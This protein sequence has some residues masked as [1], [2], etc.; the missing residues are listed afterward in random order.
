MAKMCPYRKITSV[1]SID[2]GLLKCTICTKKW[3]KTGGDCPKGVNP[4]TCEIIPKRKSKVRRVKAWAVITTVAP[5]D[6]TSEFKRVAR[7]SP[8]KD[9][10]YVTVPCTILIDE[11]WLTQS[12]NKK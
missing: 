12:E 10:H 6:G 7:A 11:K 8:E 9:P 3:P 4:E 2:G 1:T 5:P